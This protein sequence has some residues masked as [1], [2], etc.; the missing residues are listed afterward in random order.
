MAFA[1]FDSYWSVLRKLFL[2]I[3]SWNGFLEKTSSNRQ[4]FSLIHLVCLDGAYTCPVLWT[5]LQ[6]KRMQTCVTCENYAE[7]MRKVKETSFGQGRL[8]SLRWFPYM[9]STSPFIPVSVAL[10]LL[11]NTDIVNHKQQWIVSSSMYNSLTLVLSERLSC[12]TAVMT[13]TCAYPIKINS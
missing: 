12:V 5:Y 9:P 13:K 4:V 11:S 7:I 1:Y 2:L 10:C 6:T 8:S 3:P